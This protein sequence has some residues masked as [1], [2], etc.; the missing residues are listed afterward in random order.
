MFIHW[1]MSSV[2]GAEVTWAK[3][4]PDVLAP[5]PRPSAGP[6]AGLMAREV[7]DWS[8]FW[9]RPLVPGKVYDQLHKSSY[10]R[11]FIA[12]S[13]VAQAG[14]DGIKTQY[15]PG[16]NGPAAVSEMLSPFFGEPLPDF[17]ETL[18][19]PGGGDL[20]G[21]HRSYVMRRFPPPAVHRTRLRRHSSKEI[22]LVAKLCQ[23][24]NPVKIMHDSQSRWDRT[25]P[26]P[27]RAC[28]NH[29]APH[30]GC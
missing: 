5:N 24:Q 29:Q 18:E 6:A 20:A 25:R 4:F 16:G 26:T 21:R 27:L 17:L 28:R 2:V 3:E 11:Q 12:D 9:M 1:N 8:H 19:L 14:S 22:T 30:N 15:S 13:I 10:P 23:E 7:N